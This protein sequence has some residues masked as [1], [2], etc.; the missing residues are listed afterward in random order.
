[1]TTALYTITLADLGTYEVTVAADTPKEAERIARHILWEEASHLPPDMRIVA[2]E[3]EVRTAVATQPPLRTFR[4]RAT[5][6][7]D[8]AMT[9]PATCREEAVRHAKRLY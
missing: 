8:F 2:R 9:V 7:L 5:Y 6:K 4:V 3:T 1:M